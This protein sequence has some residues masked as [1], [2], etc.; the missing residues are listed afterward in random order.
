MLVLEGDLP[1]DCIVGRDLIY[2]VPRMK[3]ASENLRAVVDKCSE[4]LISNL[5]EIR[6]S[7]IANSKAQEPQNA[8]Q[9]GEII[10]FPGFKDNSPTVVADNPEPA[11]TNTTLTTKSEVECVREKVQVELNEIVADKVCDIDL[12]L[13]RHMEF[14][15]RLLEPHTQPIRS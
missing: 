8:Y 14:K 11:K 10:I 13:N 1:Y 3:E 12:E 4:E 9:E 15:I 2:R 5:D 6:D 7:P